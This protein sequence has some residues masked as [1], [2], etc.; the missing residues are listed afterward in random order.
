MSKPID[1]QHKLTQAIGDSFQIRMR[2]IVSMNLSQHLK[3]KLGKAIYQPLEDKL[4]MELWSMM[5]CQLESDINET[6]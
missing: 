2:I 3:L 1:I 6:R 5:V 4:E